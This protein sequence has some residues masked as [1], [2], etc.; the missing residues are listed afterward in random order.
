M[1]K[2]GDETRMFPTLSGDFFTYAGTHNRDMQGLFWDILLKE[3]FIYFGNVGGTK[4]DSRGLL[5]TL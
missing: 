5:D 1:A 3:L 4:K 2:T